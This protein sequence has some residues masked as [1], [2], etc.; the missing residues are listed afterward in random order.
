VPHVPRRDVAGLLLCGGK[1]TRMGADK[2]LVDFA[3]APMI[4]W[5][6]A[7][8]AECANKLVVSGGTAAHASACARAVTDAWP[9]FTVLRGMDVE[10]AVDGVEDAGPIAGLV[11]G[12]EKAKRDRVVVSACDTPLVPAGF[13]RKA[14]SFLVPAQ[15]VAPRL[16]QPEALISAWLRD[17]ALA[18]ARSALATRSGPRSLLERL[19]A[20]LVTA[21]ELIPWGFDPARFASANTPQA[22][23]AL[24]AL[25]GGGPG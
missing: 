17:P 7:A 4:A 20:K 1:S 16:E 12:F 9:R 8:L 3:G 2:A 5:C 25:L 11:A 18:E 15:V 21:Q 23:A 19:P 10:T 6:A 14:L 22:L 24:R 13:Y